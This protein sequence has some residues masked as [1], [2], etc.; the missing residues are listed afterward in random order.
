M[1]RNYSLMSQSSLAIIVS[2][3]TPTHS[4]SFPCTLT[5]DNYNIITSFRKSPPNDMKAIQ[6]LS[7]SMCHSV[8]EI[9]FRRINFKSHLP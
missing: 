3:P 7:K 6:V 5:N 8:A 1:G 9:P 2:L 4:L